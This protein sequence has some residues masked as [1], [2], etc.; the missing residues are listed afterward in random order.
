MITAYYR[1]RLPATYDL[2]LIRARARE[3]GRLWDN[4]PH[5]H[6]KAFLL[7]QTGHL[8]ATSNSYASLYLWADDAAFRGFLTSG[9]F[10]I[11]TN[12]FGRP[13]IDTH[14]VLDARRG[15]AQ[16]ARRL[17][18]GVAAGADSRRS[19]RL[20]RSLE[21]ETCCWPPASWKTLKTFS[22]AASDCTKSW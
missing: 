8:G 17:A 1:H 19:A 6:F 4:V 13:R 5:L 11:V 18:E 2:S 12:S 9:G 15:A 16:A 22:V 14:V 20:S 3:R 21:S 10:K 7:R